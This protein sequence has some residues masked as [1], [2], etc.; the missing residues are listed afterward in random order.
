MYIGGLYAT[1]LKL[2]VR[3]LLLKKEIQFCTGVE[4]S[5]ISE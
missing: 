5:A 2:S 1:N 3:G 4:P